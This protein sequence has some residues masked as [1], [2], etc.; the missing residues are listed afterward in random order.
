MKEYNLK[1]MQ[2]RVRRELDSKR[3][4]HT[5]GV[6]YTSA[7]LAM[8]HGYDVKRAQV[9]G[10][11]HD[12]AKNIP[13]EK[14]LQ[15]CTKYN[16]GIT[17]VEKRNP[18]L[19]HAKL[20]AFNAMHRYKVSDMEIINAILNH[21]TAKPAMSKLDQIIYIADYI[22]PMREKAPNLEIIRKEAF[23][24]LTKTMQLILRDTLKYLEATG[25]EIDAVTRK[26][27]EYYKNQLEDTKKEN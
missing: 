17:E 1:Q 3:Y 16:I 26:A 8:C 14:R 24:D 9:A 27:C 22:E 11:L 7:A 10:L 5:L 25:Q 19:L 18:F 12:C 21:T 2:R 15:L 13:D 6:M 23:R 20:G 4:E